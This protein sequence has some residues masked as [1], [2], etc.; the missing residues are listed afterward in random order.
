MNAKM[1]Q[2]YTKNL[3]LQTAPQVSAPWVK[4]SNSEMK[5]KKKSTTFITIILCKF[6]ILDCSHTPLIHI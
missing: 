1:S 5:E 3:L 2:H 6:E 4:N